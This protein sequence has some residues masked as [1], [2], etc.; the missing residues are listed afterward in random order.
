MA[1]KP[2]KSGRKPKPISLRIAQG[3]SLP[4]GGITAPRGDLTAPEY[5]NPTERQA[6]VE[7]AAR[8]ARIDGLSSPCDVELYTRYAVIYG[9]WR[10]AREAT[11]DSMVREGAHGGMALKSEFGLMERAERMLLS[12]EIE[13]G[14]TP[15]S[16]SRLKAT[17]S[18]GGDAFDEL[19]TEF[20][21]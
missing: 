21:A 3:G 6:F 19:M 4:T 17:E 20:G 11:A 9:R 18:T 1:G 13:L 10:R 2:G 12:I 7:L 8:V 5:L 14:L 16:R 15:S